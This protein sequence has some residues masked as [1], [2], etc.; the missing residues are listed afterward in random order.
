M[1]SLNLVWLI[2]IILPVVIELILSFAV[3]ITYIYATIYFYQQ[4]F[5]TSDF[6]YLNLAISVYLLAGYAYSFYQKIKNDINLRQSISRMIFLVPVVILFIITEILRIFG[7][8]KRTI[9]YAKIPSIEHQIKRACSISRE[10]WNYLRPFLFLNRYKLLLLILIFLGFILLVFNLP[11]KNEENHYNQINN[12]MLTL[13]KSLESNEV[14]IKKVNLDLNTV[15]NNIENKQSLIQEFSIDPNESNTPAN[16]N[17][18][19][20]KNLQVSNFDKFFISVASN[21]NQLDNEADAMKISLDNIKDLLLRYQHEIN[22]EC[23]KTKRAEHDYCSPFLTKVSN[24]LNKQNSSM[25]FVSS[26]QESVRKYKKRIDIP[27]NK[28]PL[29]Q[30]NLSKLNVKLKLKITSEAIYSSVQNV[31]KLNTGIKNSISDLKHARSSLKT[32]IQKQ[33]IKREFEDF[34]AHYEALQQSFISQEETY[35]I[36]KGFPV[37]YFISEIKAREKSMKN[38]EEKIDQTMKIS[39]DIEKQI[40]DTSLTIKKVDISIFNAAEQNNKIL[41]EAENSGCV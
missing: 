24:L 9:K 33:F 35:E 41:F 21:L 34:F 11:N 18:L 28:L 1:S 30:K 8:F 12:N 37:I 17:E 23:S 15:A 20:K 6:S 25:Q 14:L 7:L 10:H 27:K 40:E 16:T 4:L 22:I 38:L 29:W 5:I 13:D 26:I 39:Q 3:I 31:N 32:Q 19:D 2:C 36:V